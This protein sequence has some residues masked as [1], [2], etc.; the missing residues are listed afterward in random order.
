MMRQ[1]AYRPLPALDLKVE[2]TC[3]QSS[4]AS[5]DLLLRDLLRYTGTAWPAASEGTQQPELE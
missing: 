4:N 3:V 5:D 2:C 1:A